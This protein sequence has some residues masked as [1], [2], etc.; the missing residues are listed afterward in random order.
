MMSPDENTPHP[1]SMTTVVD[2]TS[3]YSPS[4]SGIALNRPPIEGSRPS[5]PPY[6]FE[7]PKPLSNETRNMRTGEDHIQGVATGPSNRGQASNMHETTQ[8]P[9]RMPSAASLSRS[10]TWQPQS[11]QRPP[12]Q[13]HPDSSKREVLL[14]PPPMQER[15]TPPDPRLHRASTYA[16]S[17]PAAHSNRSLLASSLQRGENIPRSSDARSVQQSIVTTSNGSR[18][19]GSSQGREDYRRNR[20]LPKHL[21]MPTP[22]Q[23]ALQNRAVVEQGRLD[24]W[25]GPAHSLDPSLSKRRSALVTS[26]IPRAESIPVAP[27]GGKLRKRMSI[28]GEKKE[29]ASSVAAVSFLANIVTSDKNGSR[30]EKQRRNV[31]NK[32]K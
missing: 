26:P 19:T 18:M 29:Q 21:V 17:S 15:V 14:E 8:L 25:A 5:P 16:L 13:P 9:T 27:S 3:E 11:V 22:L 1:T 30:V 6:T 12:L 7:P 2:H 23:P 20:Y 24:P 28:L 31:L 10:G 4:T 32:K